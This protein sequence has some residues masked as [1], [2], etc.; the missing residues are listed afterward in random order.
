MPLPEQNVKSDLRSG[1]PAG[2][3]AGRVAMPLGVIAVLALAWV[4]GS[5]T[6]AAQRAGRPLPPAT[7]AQPGQFWTMS[8]PLEDGRQMLLL[9]DQQ[10]RCLAIYHV[11]PAAGTLQLK[12]TR[13]LTW[14]LM[15]EEFNAMEPRPSGLKKMAEMPK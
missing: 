12:S 7:T 10:T 15:I 14:D 11:D 3:A 8:T 1:R 4:C 13:D 5:R 6:L 2:V 9:L